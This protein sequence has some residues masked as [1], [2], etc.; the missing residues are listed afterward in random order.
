MSPRKN[1]EAEKE[2]EKERLKTQRKFG[3]DYA[4]EDDLVSSD[5]GYNQP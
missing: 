1:E 4:P 5:E 3:N 2:A